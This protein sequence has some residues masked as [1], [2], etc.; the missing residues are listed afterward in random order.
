MTKEEL[1]KAFLDETGIDPK[2]IKKYGKISRVEDKFGHVTEGFEG[3]FVNFEN[4]YC[5][6]QPSYENQ[7]TKG[8]TNDDIN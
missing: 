1:Y 6:W 2:F 7:I 5:I 3:L 4:G 8:D